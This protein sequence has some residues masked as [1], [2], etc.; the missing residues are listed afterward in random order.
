MESLQCLETFPDHVISPEMCY[1]TSEVILN[2]THQVLMSY[3]DV[4][5]VYVATDDVNGYQQLQL[6][7][8]SKVYSCYGNT[9]TSHK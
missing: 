9:L 3:P 5:D 7:F 6:N 8:G 1:P 4:K 2:Q